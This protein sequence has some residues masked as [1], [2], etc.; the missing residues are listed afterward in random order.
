MK[1]LKRFLMVD[2]D[3]KQ[4]G[5]NLAA[6][7]ELL[8][9][10][11]EQWIRTEIDQHWRELGFFL[12]ASLRPEMLAGLKRLIVENWPADNSLRYG[13]IERLLREHIKVPPGFPAIWEGIEELIKEGIIEKRRSWLKLKRNEIEEVK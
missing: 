11:F 7:G 13:E 3:N 4:Y 10:F 1:H 6:A 2:D 9:P 8:R 12:Q 5:V